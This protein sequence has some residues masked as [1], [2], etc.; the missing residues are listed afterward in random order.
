M[1]ELFADIPE[2]IKHQVEIVFNLAISQNNVPSAIEILQSYL[3]TCTNEE[4]RD[5]ADFYFSMKLEELV[6]GSS[7]N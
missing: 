4:E 5:F 7:T 3:K 2:E 6:N 1:T